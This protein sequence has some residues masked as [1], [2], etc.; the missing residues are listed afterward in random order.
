[1]QLEFA[2]WENA[3]VAEENHTAK[4]FAEIFIDAPA[5]KV[6]EVLTDWDKMPEWSNFLVG[7]TGDFQKGG[8]VTVTILQAFAGHTRHIKLDHTLIHFEEGRL[9]GWS[10]PLMQGSV[11]DNHMYIVEPLPDGRTR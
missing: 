1:M 2:D 3:H 5:E 6:W 10:D 11:H 9:F 7:L 8:R 4:I